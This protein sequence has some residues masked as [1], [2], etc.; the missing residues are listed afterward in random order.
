MAGELHQR[1][2]R[3]RHGELVGALM[4]GRRVRTAIL[5]RDASAKT[6]CRVI[7]VGRPRAAMKA[8]R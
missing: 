7:P 3:A 4:K 5:Q 1:I 6:G 8:R 2:V